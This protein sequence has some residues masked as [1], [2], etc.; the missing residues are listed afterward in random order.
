[1]YKGAL[2]RCLGVVLLSV[3]VAHAQSRLSIRAASVRPVDGW[4]QM[5]A[6]HCQTGCVLWVAPTAALTESDIEKAEPEVRDDAFRAIKIV[7]TDAGAKK[8]RDLTAAQLNKLIALVVDD[9]VIWTPTV[10]G[11][12]RAGAKNNLLN[13]NTPQGLT[14]E[15]VQRMMGILRP[16][17][18]PFRINRTFSVWSNPR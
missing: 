9:K 3:G 11:I 15:E 10:A 1:M 16:G 7:F 12:L 5:Q 14:E 8:M 17:Q 6:E 18:V 2:A 13:G 4:Q